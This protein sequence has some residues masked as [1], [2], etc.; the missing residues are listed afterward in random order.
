MNSMFAELKLLHENGVQA[1]G[2]GGIPQSTAGGSLES[3]KC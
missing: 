3:F 2:F 1:G